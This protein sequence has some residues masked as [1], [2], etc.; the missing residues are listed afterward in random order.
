VSEETSVH[1]LKVLVANELDIPVE[2][3]RLVFKGKPMH[4]NFCFHISLYYFF[5]RALCFYLSI[6]VC[7][8][9]LESQVVTGVSGP[10]S[11]DENLK[12]TEAGHNEQST[13]CY[14]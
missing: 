12:W 10:A 1:E 14:N 5:V 4:G 7:V 3:Q 9:A 6:C 2:R 11:I 8:H 13:S